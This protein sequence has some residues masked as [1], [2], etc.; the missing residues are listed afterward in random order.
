M[1]ADR[2]A[3]GP[4]PEYER[5]LVELAGRRLSERA[6][7]EDA[8][9]RTEARDDPLLDAFGANHVLRALAHGIVRWHDD[10]NLDCQAEARKIERESERL[11]EALRRVRPSVAAQGAAARAEGPSDE[12]YWEAEKRW[13]DRP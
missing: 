10:P 12:D 4:D 3:T 5:Q 8:A 7:G 2:P 1:T 9:P 6:T 13:L 11:H